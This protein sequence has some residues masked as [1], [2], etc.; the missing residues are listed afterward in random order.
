MAPYW[1]TV[2]LLMLVLGVSFANTRWAAQLAQV[3]IAHHGGSAAPGVARQGAVPAQGVLAQHA[4]TL[5]YLVTLAWE[6]LLLG[7]VLW[8]LRMRRVPVRRLLGL[9]RRGAIEWWTDAGIASGFWFASALTLAACSLALR[10]VH[11]DPGTMRAALIRLA[12]ASALQLAMWI[13]LSISAGFCEEMIF[14]GYLHQQFSALTRRM[15]LGATISAV[16]FGLAHGYQ[17]LSGVLLIT[18]Y[19]VFFSVLAHQRRSLRAG[20]LAHAWQDASSGVALFLLVHVLH[21]LPQ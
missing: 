8:G 19:G 3:A 13:A 5:T 18:L 15:W 7:F 1:H 10:R 6:W 4:R 21:R 12:P 17:G 20:I 2:A 16:V 9:R 14:R 11:V